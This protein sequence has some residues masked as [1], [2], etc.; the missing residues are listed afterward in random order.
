VD[1]PVGSD[2]LDEGGGLLRLLFRRA[3]GE[4]ERHEPGVAAFLERF[5]VGVGDGDPGP[6]QRRLKLLRTG[7]VERRFIEGETQLRR[8]RGGFG[9][10]GGADRIELRAIHGEA[11]G[12]HLHD[13]REQLHF[14]LGHRIKRGGRDL[15]DERGAER[16]QVAHVARGVGELVV[17]EE[18]AAPIRSAVIVARGDAEVALKAAVE[19]VAG[20]RAG[21]EQP[22]GGQRAEHAR[23]FDAALH[24]Q[25]QCIELRVVGDDLRRGQ[26]RPER[27]QVVAR[28]LEVEQPRLVP[29]DAETQQPDLAAPRV[30]AVAL[31][32]AERLDVERDGP[33]LADERGSLA[34]RVDTSQQ[35]GRRT[36]GDLGDLGDVCRSFCTHGCVNVCLLLWGNYFVY[37][38]ALPEDEAKEIR[39][40][41]FRTYGQLRQWHGE[42]HLQA[43]KGVR[44]IR[45][46]LGRRR[47]IPQEA[48]AWE[49]FT[50][51][52]NTPVQ[53][54]C[55]DGM[56]R[57]LVQL[58]AALPS[59]A[60]I[61]STVHDEIIVEAPQHEADDVR[62][63]VEA[64]MV[65]AMAALFPQVPVEVEANV[66]AS[67]GE[68]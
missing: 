28:R 58:A 16:V 10:S 44:E 26:C 29:F 11:C 30:E 62:R 2:A 65:E 51:L 64:V 20:A 48:S 24:A 35:P 23:Q 37:G 25:P 32:R 55:A 40:K 5:L 52:V 19:I 17:G 36:G 56:K 22:R 42:S 41:F 34:Q 53:G 38:V 27:S 14:E 63:T 13:D 4:D 39:A 12:F 9:D 21:D 57:A 60:R 1:A 54:G 49:R 50:A 61:V 7:D 31:A 47:L 66:C 68:K 43:E 67:W 15:G 33:G 18:H 45:T 46:V 6:R 8:T 3:I 59:S